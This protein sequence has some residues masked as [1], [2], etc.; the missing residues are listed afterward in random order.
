MRVSLDGGKAEAVPGA[1]LP[2]HFA[3]E[4]VSFVA[5]DGKTIGVIADMSDPVTHD[6]R[7]QL[8][9]LSVD[10][11][12]PVRKVELDPRYAGND[13]FTDVVQ[14]VPNS[15]AVV[16]RITEK[17]VD[18][19]WQQPL[20]GSPGH[21]LTQFNSERI[22]DFHSSPDG[23]SVAVIRGHDISDVVLLRDEK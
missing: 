16:Y 5:P 23:K 22:I 10:G 6:A 4:G 9:I 18:N 13:S 12:S 3:L 21:Q 17:G 11:S 15:N 20:D 7:A 2:G 8:A 14:L 1:E 19:L